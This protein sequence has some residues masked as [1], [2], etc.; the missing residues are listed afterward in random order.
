MSAN[1][2][3]LAALLLMGANWLAVWCGWRVLNALTKPAIILM[4]LGWFI[5]SGGLVYPKA[6]FALGLGFALFGDTLLMM[7]G[8]GFAAGMLAFFGTHMA[9]IAGFNLPWRGL[10]EKTALL[11]TTGIL[12]WVLVFLLLRRIARGSAQLRKLMMPLGIYNLLIALMVCSA[13]AANLRPDWPPAAAR[14]VSAG[15]LLFLA[16]DTLLA[17]DRFISPLG[18]AP[19][20]KRVTYQ[21]GQAAI[22]AGVL[23]TS[24]V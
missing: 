16:S 15:A 19:V 1:S 21:L 2:W 8:R 10:D 6:W 11:F 14:L 13:L 7:P 20:V 5:L 9:Y 4:L 23:L 18:W 12:L 17:A 24:S 3:L 22:V